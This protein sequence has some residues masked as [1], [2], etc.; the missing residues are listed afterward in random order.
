VTRHLAVPVAG[1]LLAA[2]VA[3][4][5]LGPGRFGPRIR[6]AAPD[7]FDGAFTFCRVL[8]RSRLRGVGNGWGV[9]YPRAD[10]NLPFRLSEL[11]KISISRDATGEINHVVVR[12]T[13]AELFHCPFV[14]MTEP[15]GVVFDDAEA[16]RLRDYLLKGGFLW[17]DDFWGQRAWDIWSSEIAK[18]LSPARYPIVDL[19]LTHG[20][21][22]ALYEV[23]RI[24]Q[25]PS[26][27]FWGGSGGLTSEQGIDSAEP[28]VRAIVDEAGRIMVLMTHNTDFG[29]AFEREGDNHEYF[30][31][32]A[33]DG[34]AFGVN[35]ILYAMTH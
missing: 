28:H 15:G 10:T 3:G 4:A 24:P 26:I 19:P 32:F 9:D 29:D 23:R 27:G 11:T 21:F 31:Q 25:I 8:F 5:Q 1:L 20:L 16:A 13:D 18:V 12:L 30:L 35:A 6:M 7:S 22:H 2:S 14:M 33:P 17:A 34:Y